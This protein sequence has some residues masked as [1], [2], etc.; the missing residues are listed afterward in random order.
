MHGGLIGKQDALGIPASAA[1]DL[2]KN[3]VFFVKTTGYAG[4]DN[5]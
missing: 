4:L 3:K 1:V 2:G 5:W